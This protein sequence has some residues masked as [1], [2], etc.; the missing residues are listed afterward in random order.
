MLRYSDTKEIPAAEEGI[1][2]GRGAADM[3]SILWHV[4]T[5]VLFRRNAYKG[6]SCALTGV[7]LG[8]VPIMYAPFAETS[9]F[10][11][12]VQPFSAF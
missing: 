5:S 11:R 7:R 12:N 9:G 1:E 10:G 2:F 4:G 8:H 6:A 3:E